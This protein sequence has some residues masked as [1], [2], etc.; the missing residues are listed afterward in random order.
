MNRGGGK[1]LQKEKNE[2]H[3]PSRRAAPLC[4]SRAPSLASLERGFSLA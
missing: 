2:K 1:K 4:L 3:F